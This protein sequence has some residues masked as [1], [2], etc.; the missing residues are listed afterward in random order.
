M[1]G[2]GCASGLL[3][4]GSRAGDGGNSEGDAGG[5]A[6]R[7]EPWG[8]LEGSLPCA[9][10]TGF[11]QKPYYEII[12]GSQEIGEK[13]A[14]RSPACTSDPASS[15]VSILGG[16]VQRLTKTRRKAKWR[17]LAQKEGARGACVQPFPCSVQETWLVL[18]SPLLDQQWIFQ[19]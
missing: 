16:Y 19:L 11:F 3:R 5:Q 10:R 8:P 15:R 9:E 4:L 7:G 12:R 18:F 6:R 2:A 14:G 17:E 13:W 1:Q